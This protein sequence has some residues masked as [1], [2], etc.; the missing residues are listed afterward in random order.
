MRMASVSAERCDEGSVKLSM[1]LSYGS[2]CGSVERLCTLMLALLVATSL[3][4]GT[5]NGQTANRRPIKLVVFGDSLTAGL[6]LPAREAFPVKLEKAL[7]AKGLSVDVLNAGV[8]G[9]TTTDGLA[10]L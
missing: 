7:R 3:A 4:M 1:K 10:R 9:D 5:A 2:L 6:G 8:S